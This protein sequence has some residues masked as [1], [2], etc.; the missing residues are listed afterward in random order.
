MARRGTPIWRGAAVTAKHYRRTTVAW[1]GV[2]VTAKH[3]HRTAAALP[4]HYRRTTTTTTTPPQRVTW[5]VGDSTHSTVNFLKLYNASKKVLCH[6][7]KF[8]I[9]GSK[10]YECFSRV[11]CKVESYSICNMYTKS[12]SVRMFFTRFFVKSKVAQSFTSFCKFKS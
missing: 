11:F 4:P 1:R 5:L 10:L 6:H 7:T 9:K 2:A 3:Y 12:F 8:C